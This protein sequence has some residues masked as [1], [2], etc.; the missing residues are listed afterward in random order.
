MFSIDTLLIAL[1][2]GFVFI[3]FVTKAYKKSI[4]TTIYIVSFAVT[5]QLICDVREHTALIPMAIGALI[6]LTRAV[7]NTNRDQLIRR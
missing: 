3:L 7:I 1:S 4:T 5:M 2:L 6:S